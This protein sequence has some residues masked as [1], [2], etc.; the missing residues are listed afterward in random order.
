M[1]SDRCRQDIQDAALH[2]HINVKVAHSCTEEILKGTISP[3]LVYIMRL[4]IYQ[5][6]QKS[7]G[8]IKCVR[9]RYMS[10]TQLTW[11]TRSTVAVF[12]AVIVSIVGTW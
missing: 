3:V 9:D 11:V 1:S 5:K 7:L 2:N 6:L 4:Y 8:V 10:T 12:A